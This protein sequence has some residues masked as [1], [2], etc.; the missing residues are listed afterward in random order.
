LW[1]SV[2]GMALAGGIGAYGE[3]MKLLGK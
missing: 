2:F 3:V 1:L